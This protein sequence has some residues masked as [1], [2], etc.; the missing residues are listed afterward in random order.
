MA[1]INVPGLVASDVMELLGSLGYGDV[2]AYTLATLPDP[3]AWTKRTCWATDLFGVGG[4]LVSEGGFWK[5][6]RPLLAGNQVSSN[7]ATVPLVTP[8]T[9]ILTGSLGLGVTHTVT[10]GFGSGFALPSPGYRQRVVKPSGVL[11]TLNVVGA[12]T[13]ALTGWADYEF[14]G[15]AWNQTASGGLL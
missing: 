9:L 15:G 8:P 5:P 1:E 12:L 3:T 14:D 4:R 2:G 7:M 11:G 6:I 13:K 10:L